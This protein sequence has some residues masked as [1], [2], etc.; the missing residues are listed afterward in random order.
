MGPNDSFFCSSQLK[1]V[2]VKGLSSCVPHNEQ[3]FPQE[4]TVDAC[5]LR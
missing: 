1:K 4:L 3:E 2:E 5:Q